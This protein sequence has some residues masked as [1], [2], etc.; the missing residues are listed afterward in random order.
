MSNSDEHLD[1]EKLKEEGRKGWFVKDADDMPQH[2]KFR[3]S[4]KQGGRGFFGPNFGA[5]HIIPEES[6][7]SSTAKL[8]QQQVT[9]IKYI[10]PFILNRPSNMLGLPSFWSFDVYYKV[11][12]QKKERG[13]E[14]S[15]S[16]YP[17]LSA[18][19]MNSYQEGTRKRWQQRVEQLLAKASMTKYSPENHPIHIPKTWGHTEYSDEVANRL[20]KQVWIVLKREKSKHKISKKSLQSIEAQLKAI[21]TSF[22][23][24]LTNRGATSLDLW[25]RRKNPDDNGWYGPYTMTDIKKNP[26]WG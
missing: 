21:E 17:G 3:T 23:T 11:Q 14:D 6:I 1:I 15:Q 19:W 16:E 9:D 26:I 24:K 8:D 18:K 22:Y 20:T 4:C 10:T 12:R 5:H 7:N 2:K 13:Q 25:E